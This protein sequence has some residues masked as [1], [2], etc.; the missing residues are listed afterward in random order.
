MI[1]KGVR[2]GSIWAAVVALLPSLTACAAGE[3]DARTAAQ[4]AG[5]PGSL[6]NPRVLNCANRN[7]EF[8]GE[9][10]ASRAA[11][12]DDLVVGPL[13]IPG[14]LAWGDARA[15][16]YGSGHKFKVGA[17]VRKGRTIT[18]SIPAK[19]HDSAGLLYS[20]PS[21]NARTPA[22]ADHSV[23]FTAC[24]DHDTMFVGGFYVKEPRCV[25]LEFRVPGEP[26]VR[27]EISF[28]NGAC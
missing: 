22:E 14:L 13:L 28:F 19:F 26:V 4:S 1:F 24:S 10:T 8:P 18:V 21:R 5:R 9:K 7:G 25:P 12:P 3:A 16:Q 27:R 2:R 11:E 15:E 6:A 17:L 23:S 20:E